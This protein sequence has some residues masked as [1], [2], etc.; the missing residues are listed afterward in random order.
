MN[1]RASAT[2]AAAAAL[3]VAA[4]CKNG[5]SLPGPAAQGPS[6]GCGS[7]TGGPIPPD[8]ASAIARAVGAKP[9]LPGVAI[10]IYDR[11]AAYTYY[12]GS[13]V[14]DSS[15]VD[16][17]TIFELGSLTKTFTAAMLAHEY[18]AN[19]AVDPG[20]SPVR[21]IDML[22]RENDVG[23]GCP[24]PAMP[25]PVPTPGYGVMATMTLSTL[26]THTSGLD[27]VDPAFDG[28][29]ER[30]CMS[31]RVFVH[32]VSVYPL[33]SPVPTPPQPWVYSNNGYGTL[34]YVLQGIEHKD[35]FAL[36]QSELLTPLGMTHT[37]DVGAVPS[38]GYAQGYDCT[39]SR[40]VPHWPLDPWPAAGALRSTLPDMMNY[41]AA[42]MDKSGTPPEI[43]AAMQRAETPVAGVQTGSGGDQGM[44]W[45]V[46]HFRGLAI[47]NKDGGTDGFNSWIGIVVPASGAQALGVVVLTNRAPGMDAPCTG[48][49]GNPA[50]DIGE[51]ILENV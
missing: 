2:V 15:C 51:S 35:W 17:S 8:V 50:D 36:A 42:A 18:L 1:V 7:S 5:A 45:A 22:G 6:T 3:L 43:G 30:P 11:G 44:A 23:D 46:G 19:A 33:P 25:T 16:G 9:G 12:A 31:P 49:E 47:T 34:G 24:P 10:G 28:I 37:Y 38:A 32:Y 26:S 40:A 20:Q 21:W 29:A 39:G 48:Y 41:L 14:K 13:A 27:D 4:G